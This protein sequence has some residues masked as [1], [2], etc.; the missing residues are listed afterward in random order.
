MGAD[1]IGSP[2]AR[3]VGAPMERVAASA[4]AIVYG[5][6]DGLAVH[7]YTLFYRPASP[8]GASPPTMA[9]PVS[10]R[11]TER[12]PVPIRVR[13][14]VGWRPRTLGS[15]ARPPPAYSIR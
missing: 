2:V 11:A 5:Y 1:G 12:Q 14:R 13:G 4:A 6:W 8:P 10:S 3:L 15:W 9:R 7:D